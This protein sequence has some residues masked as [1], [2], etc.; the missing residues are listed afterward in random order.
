M[1]LS[2]P[3]PGFQGHCI[4]TSRI[5]HQ[6]SFLFYP[7]VNLAQC[8]SFHNTLTLCCWNS[9]ITTLGRPFIC[10]CLI[11]PPPRGQIMRQDVRRLSVCRVHEALEL[12][13]LTNLWTYIGPKL[14]TERPRKTKI[15][16]EVAHVTRDSD[17]T[18]KVKRWKVKV[19]CEAGVYC[20]G[21]PRSLLNTVL[22]T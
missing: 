14:T 6:L 5:S 3:Q 1:T 12:Y 15:G 16:T 2:D 19:T 20:G 10:P 21:L 11:M 17:T 7:V 9:I 18:S 13:E 22:H 4:L 8:L